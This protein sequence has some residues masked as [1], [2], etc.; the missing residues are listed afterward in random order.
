[1]RTAASVATLLPD[2]GS[3]YRSDACAQLKAAYA[4]RIAGQ[5]AQL[6]AISSS[7]CRHINSNSRD[8]PLV[9]ALLGPVGVG[10]SWTARVTAQALLSA[11]PLL[12]GKC[13]AGRP[14]CRALLQIGSYTFVAA[15][16]E[17]RRCCAWTMN[18][19]RTAPRACFERA[20]C[21]RTVVE[22]ILAAGVQLHERTAPQDVCACGDVD[23][24]VWQ[25]HPA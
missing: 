13:S 1:M 6:T 7:I 10:K 17:V 12:P 16:R 2:Q 24:L 22:R 23:A 11:E 8:R 15:E 25:A 21:E 9:I 19:E 5:R 18:R 3:R 14:P 4:A 20:E